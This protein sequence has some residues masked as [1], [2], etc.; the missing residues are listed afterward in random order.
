MDLC[1]LL[2][3][4]CIS[5]LTVGACPIAFKESNLIKIIRLFFDIIYRCSII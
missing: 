5:L 4:C 1:W 2:I 3:I